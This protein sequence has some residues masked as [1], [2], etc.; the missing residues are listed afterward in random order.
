[1]FHRFHRL[2]Y[3]QSA[4][5][6]SSPWQVIRSYHATRAV[7]PD[8]IGVD[9]AQVRTKAGDR[10]RRSGACNARWTCIS[11]RTDQRWPGQGQDRSQKYSP[12]GQAGRHVRHRRLLVAPQET[13]APVSWSDTLAALPCACSESE[14]LRARGGPVFWTDPEKCYPI[15]TIIRIQ[16]LKWVK[17]SIEFG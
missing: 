10:Q 2:K 5:D 11:R 14:W 13:G 4:R 3:C 12:Q 17:E 16:C 8:G 1:M 9:G 6:S 15:P 7:S